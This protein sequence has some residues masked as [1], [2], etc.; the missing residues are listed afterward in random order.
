MKRRLFTILLPVV[1]ALV[2]SG[3][4]LAAFTGKPMTS[5]GYIVVA[6]GEDYYLTSQVMAFGDTTV[7]LNAAVDIDSLSQWRGDLIRLEVELTLGEDDQW[8][9]QSA[10]WRRASR[11]DILQ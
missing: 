4:A 11:G 10:Q 3:V 9:L 8:R 1:A 6:D 2:I 5:T 7:G